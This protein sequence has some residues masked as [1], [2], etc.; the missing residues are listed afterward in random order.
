MLFVVHALRA[1]LD[2]LVK[3][4]KPHAHHSDFRYVYVRILVDLLKVPELFLALDL[5]AFDIGLS[6][7]FIEGIAGS[8]RNKIATS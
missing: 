3:T 6:F 8:K 4:L 2:D 7:R 1:L 5:Y